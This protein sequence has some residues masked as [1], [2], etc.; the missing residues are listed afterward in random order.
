[1]KI[2]E[3]SATAL[4]HILKLLG[5]VSLSSLVCMT[6][7]QGYGQFFPIAVAAEVVAER[8]TPLVLRA[9][10]CGATKFN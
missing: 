4:L 5:R 8:W 9:F 6:E 10:F 2:N 1:M 3:F 7:T